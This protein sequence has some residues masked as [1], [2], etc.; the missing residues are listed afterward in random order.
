MKLDHKLPDGS[1]TSQPG[2]PSA[3]SRGGGIGV[4][5]GGVGSWVMPAASLPVLSASAAG[6]VG[7]VHFY[8]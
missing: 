1:H 2:F 4:S 6:G 3:F 8:P 5:G 7:G